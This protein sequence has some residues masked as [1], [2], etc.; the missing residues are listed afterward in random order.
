MNRCYL[1]I[2]LAFSACKPAVL[3]PEALTAF[4]ADEKNGLKKSVEVEGVKIEVAYRPTDLWIYQE[5]ED[6]I[7]SPGRIDSLRSKYDRYLYFVVSLSKNN[8]EALHQ[9]EGG[10]GQYSDLVQTLSFR[11][12]EYTTLTTAVQDTI[13]MG[14]FTLNRTYG[15][16]TATELLFVFNREKAVDSEWVQLN[17]NE[18]GLGVGNQRFRFATE[19]LKNV[20]ALAFAGR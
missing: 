12:P 9:V 17:L 3:S 14:D 8:K 6:D 4:V 11:M 18:F 20:P 15:L 2:L 10:F 13:H 7:V 16:S 1:L 5:I 19:D